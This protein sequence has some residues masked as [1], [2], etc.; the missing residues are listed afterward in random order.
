M[1]SQYNPRGKRLGPAE[2]RRRAFTLIEL[3]V[4][5]AIIAILAAMLLPALAR[6]KEMAKR[7]SCVNNVKQ[8]GLAA[9]MYVDDNDG[10]YPPRVY[11]KRWTTSLQP[12]YV[13]IK[14]LKCPSDSPNP[15]TFGR[16]DATYPADG[17]P[18]SYIINGW[19]DFFQGTNNTPYLSGSSTLVMPESA[20]KEPT[21][22]I[23]FGEK[24][25]S[26]GHYYMDYDM[27]DDLQQLDQSRHSTSRINSGVNS[28]GG[29]DYAFA[30]GSARFLKFGKA[31]NPVNLWGVV[32]SFR[33]TAITFP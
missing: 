6:A 33:Q 24:N 16:G 5:I 27:Y 28:G 8:L 9:T 31:F 10:Y 11:R 22:T 14:L 25:S 15:D 30:D 4:V 26:S 32:E 7:I 18:R 17:A 19:N 13:D 12:Y 2:D 23:V 29:S 21:E 3:L 20:I 1:R